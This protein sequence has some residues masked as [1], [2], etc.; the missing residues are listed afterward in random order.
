MKGLIFISTCIISLF[1]TI[2]S[3]TIDMSKDITMDW[4]E[5]DKI[6]SCTEIVSK[7]FQKDQVNLMISNYKNFYFK[8]LDRYY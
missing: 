1:I 3:Q 4:Q 2:F 7:K 8:E 6:L 5:K